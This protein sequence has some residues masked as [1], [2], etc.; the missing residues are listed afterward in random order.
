MAV[1][2]SF[3]EVLG[4]VR[5]VS[6]VRNRAYIHNISA[7]NDSNVLS[8]SDATRGLSDRSAVAC[9]SHSQNTPQSCK[10]HVTNVFIPLA[11]DLETCRNVYDKP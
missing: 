4:G 6:Q 2:C 7:L 9:H 10:K 8:D 11:L 5:S 3:K 1:V